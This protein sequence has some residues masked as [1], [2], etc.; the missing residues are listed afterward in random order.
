MVKSKKHDDKAS[1]FDGLVMVCLLL[2]HKNHKY[3]LV[4][5][6][7]GIDFINRIIPNYTELRKSFEYLSQRGLIL[8]NDDRY[9]PSKPIIKKYENITARSL[10][11][12][13]DYMTALLDSFDKKSAHVRNCIPSIEEYNN[14]MDEYLGKVH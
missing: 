1:F 6:L 4:S 2:S 12:Q 10:L 9:L 11:K 8:K 13:V 3:T 7:Q 5:I 14:A